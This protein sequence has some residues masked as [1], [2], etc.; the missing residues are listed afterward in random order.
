[1]KEHN[2][3]RIVVLLATLLLSFGLC[4]AADEVDIATASG[5]GFADPDTIWIDGPSEF[6]IFL[7]N[8]DNALGGMSL[9]FAIGSPDG[10][11]WAWLEMPG[12]YTDETPGAEPRC[13]TMIPGTRLDIGSPAGTSGD[14]VADAFDMTGLLVTMRKPLTGSGADSIMVGGVSLMK[15]LPAGGL[16]HMLTY[17]FEAFI[18]DDNVYTMTF[19]SAFFPPSGSFVMVDVAGTAFTP[20]CVWTYPKAPIIRPVKKAPNY[21]PVF[22]P[23][24][25]MSV[26]HCGPTEC[27]TVSA[28][29]Q[30]G[31]AI[32]FSYEGTTGGGTATVTDNGDGTADVCYTPVVGD[33]GSAVTITVGAG[34]AFHPMPCVTANVNVTVGNNAP[35]ATQVIPE[36]FVGKGNCIPAGTIPVV[37]EDADACD[38]LTY[39][40]DPAGTG[41]T[42]DMATGELIWCTTPADIGTHNMTVTVYDGVPGD[43]VPPPKAIASAPAKVTVLAV[44][45][46]EVEIEKTH[47]TLQ[48]HFVDVK[49]TLNLGSEAMGGFDFLIGYDASALTFTEAN[50]S[51]YLEG[52]GW[53]Y[54]TYRYNWNGNCGN[55]CPSG[56]L[57]IVGLA[58]TNNGPNHPDMNCI[59]DMVL[60]DEII[61]TLTFFVSNDRTLE[62][63]Y[64]PI[65]FYWMDCGDN[66][67]S[68]ASGD[69]LAINR[70]IYDFEGAQIQD[71]TYGFPGYVG[72]PDVPCLDGDKVTPVRFIDF[73][74]GGIDIVCA[75]SIDARGDINVN[76]VK[77][78]IA[79]AVMFTNYFIN[80]LS[81]FGTHMEASIAASDVNADGIAL[82]VADLVYLIRVIIGDALPYAKLV[83]G[84]DIDV[85]AQMQ[86]DQLVV[87]YDAAYDAGAALLTFEV[88]GN[89]GTPVVGQGAANMDLKYGVDGTK[90]T[91]LVY[92]IGSN[93]IT[94]GKNVLVS[95]PVDGSAELIGAE[96][97][98]YNGS[99]M[100][101]TV[102]NLP[103]A[104]DLQQNY[105]NPFNPKTRI[106]LNLP[107]ASDW[108]IKVYNV[109]GQVVKDYSGHSDA[110][111][112]E[113]IWEGTDNSGRSV[114]SGIYFYKATAN[115]FSATKKMVLMK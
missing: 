21:C 38:V 92:D 1:M 95:I 54:F 41:C 10:A 18:P 22:D 8:A 115:S 65:R 60:T 13:V 55:A 104:F 81:A 25:P 17:N 100:D 26:S 70:F 89:V 27:V 42:I 112:V 31:D 96:V 73:I 49:I 7:G 47:G 12:G 61:A 78:E 36:V 58:E 6:H 11:T 110:G 74:N 107:V 113:V 45:P 79:D 15:N 63:M 114:A 24:P 99:T 9:G 98:D 69:S 90:L 62:C 93:A 44:E 76:G 20:G 19:D 35:T 48:G 56:L 46:W 87:N 86:G 30:D 102:R 64:V 14:N 83:P 59:K 80:G 16:E 32:A 43:G 101:V 37:G 34:D 103:S 111:I 84:L 3:K 91:V 5:P 28:T 53:E 105:P 94:A 2:M 50:L 52:C 88:K 23:V 39:Y 109:A 97:S 57:R 68:V 40:L 85:S 67:I 51:A 75:D 106:A 29:D 4:N 66:T 77:N 82:S 33:V 72:A 71:Y 108:S